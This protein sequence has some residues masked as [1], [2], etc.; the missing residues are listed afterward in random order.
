[1]FSYIRRAKDSEDFVVVVLNFKP[2]SYHNYRLGVPKEG[3][4][5]EVL[6]SDRNYYHGSNQYNGLP[7]VASEGICH[8]KPYFIEM[9]I[10]PYGAVI[11]K[12]RAKKME[13]VVLE[14]EELI[15]TMEAEMEV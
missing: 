1:M 6:N 5:V 14:E 8:G 13:E 7:L 15:E 4:Y 10:P 11:L 3:E 12:Y 2:V 9:T